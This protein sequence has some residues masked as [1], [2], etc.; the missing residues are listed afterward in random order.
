VKTRTVVSFSAL[1]LLLAGG[2]ALLHHRGTPEH[3]SAPQAELREPASGPRTHLSWT[4]GQAYVYRF[5]WENETVVRSSALAPTGTD[6][7]RALASFEGELTLRSFGLR[8]DAYLLGARVG[9][10]AKHQVEV[11]GKDALP[12]DGSASKAFDGR[13]AFVEID[14]EG[15]VRAISFTPDAPE[16]FRYTMR[17]LLTQLHMTIPSEGPRIWSATEPGPAGRAKIVW[18]ATAPLMFMR[19]RHSYEALTSLPPKIAGEHDDKLESR[20]SVTLAEA[21]YVQS[22]RD[23]E[24][25]TVRAK[26]DGAALLQERAAFGIDHERTEA[27]DASAVDTSGLVAWHPGDPEDAKIDTR[28][29]Q[30][31]RLAGDLTIQQVDMQF[32]MVGVGQHVASD[33]LVRSMALLRLQPKLASDVLRLALDRE[34]PPAGRELAADVLAAAGTPQAQS[35]LRSLIDS[36]V[37]R[38]SD[39]Q[40]RHILQR[41]TFVRDPQPETLRLVRS[42]YVTATARGDED[43]RLAAAYTLGSS[44][45]NLARKGD[46]AGARAIADGLARDL[47]RSKTA[48]DRRGLIAA[49]GNAGTP[50]VLPA[51]RTQSTSDE[52]SVRAETAHALR[53]LDTPEA[54]D[55]L[56]TMVGDSEG[57][58]A[59]SALDS[60][61]QQS[62]GEPEVRRLADLTSRG[63]IPHGAAPAL[64]TVLSHH[65]SPASE[66]EAA[67]RALAASAPGDVDTQGRVQALLQQMHPE[68]EM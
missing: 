9:T 59:T 47:E 3:D 30:L 63:A 34:M 46:E 31:S 29:Q 64:L 53:K 27:F 37:V 13:E 43:G 2:A 11:F 67:L 17:A 66:V 8:G 32:F 4:A 58:V 10:L 54:K 22:I 26:G 49:L 65:L 35:A 38:A 33:F 7:V 45:G 39:T 68:T 6:E 5:T 55:L 16:M 19:T 57:E 61:A 56:Y 42:A 24:T 50:E 62:L 1:A 20:T 60:L 44:A 23:M 18:A 12:D 15:G 40:Y 41:V 36:P 14:K 28:T 48:Q 51:L 52:A 21:G 25:L